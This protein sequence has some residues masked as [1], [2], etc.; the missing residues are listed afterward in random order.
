AIE[1]R[2]RLTQREEVPSS[3]SDVSI[4]PL[5]AEIMV[6]WHRERRL[7]PGH[8]REYDVNPKVRG[9]SRDA[10]RIVIRDKK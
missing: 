9:R 8:Y 10:E 1:G 7:P 5:L 4:V 3:L 6:Q 2:E